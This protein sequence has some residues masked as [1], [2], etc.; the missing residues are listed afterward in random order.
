MSSTNDI[1]VDEIETMANQ[2]NQ[3]NQNAP[4]VPTKVEGSSSGLIFRSD[5]ALSKGDSGLL[6]DDAVSVTSLGSSKN[7]ALRTLVITRTVNLPDGGIGKQ[8]EVIK[9]PRIINAYLRQKQLMELN[10]K[11]TQDEIG[12]TKKDRKRENKGLLK[13][14]RCGAIGHMRTNKTCPNFVDDENS[15]IKNGG[16]EEQQQQ[17]KKRKQK[18]KDPLQQRK[19]LLNELSNVLLGIWKDIAATP[20]SYP[21]QK[22]VNTKQFPDYLTF[23]S[24]PMDLST[25][26]NK[27]RKLQYPTA[28]TFIEDIKLI[29]DNCEKYNGPQHSL[30][31]I[32]NSMYER[33]Q[34][35]VADNA[36]K[37]KELEEMIKANDNGSLI[38]NSLTGNNELIDDENEKIEDEMQNE[39]ETSDV[40]VLSMDI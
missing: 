30:T 5:S 24:N 32:I 35:M 33:T 34:R 25:V 19:K 17:P 4:N 36:N 9:D 21:F 23:V 7:K 2:S 11:P 28:D 27:L 12:G 13:C 38:I 22:P 29:R 6:D 26:K 14:G 15:S 31:F 8:E 16:K 20:H 39:K 1:P 10:K 3:P 40:D 18:P 37:I